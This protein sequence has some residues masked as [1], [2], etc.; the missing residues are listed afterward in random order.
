[1]AKSKKRDRTKSITL[2]ILEIDIQTLTDFFETDDP[3]AALEAAIHWAAGTY[4]VLSMAG[5]FKM[6]GFDEDGNLKDD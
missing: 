2:D 1:M 4:P 5:Q 6:E 3:K